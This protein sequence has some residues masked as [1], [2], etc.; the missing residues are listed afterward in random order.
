MLSFITHIFPY[1][2]KGIHSAPDNNFITR[3]CFRFLRNKDM[4]I[5]RGGNWKVKLNWTIFKKRWRRQIEEK[6]VAVFWSIMW[7]AWRIKTCYDKKTIIILLSLHK[8]CYTLNQWYLS[9]LFLSKLW[10]E[11][12]KI[13]FW[14]LNM[15]ILC[16]YVHN[17]IEKSPDS[18]SLTSISVLHQHTLSTIIRKEQLENLISQIIICWFNNRFLLFQLYCNNLDKILLLVFAEIHINSGPQRVKE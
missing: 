14:N 13:L 2:W 12:N 10:H 8:V 7:L 18:L 4:T 3:V 11:V 5:T 16:K 15:I 1:F 17:D 6:S 9:N